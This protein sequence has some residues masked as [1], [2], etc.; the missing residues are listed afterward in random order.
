MR[1][2][3]TGTICAPHPDAIS[4]VSALPLGFKRRQTQQHTASVGF[5][6]HGSAWEEDIVLQK[7]LDWHPTLWALLGF[8][9]RRG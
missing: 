9:Y 4:A 8:W 1:L 6:T 3:G 7:A 2:G 5:L